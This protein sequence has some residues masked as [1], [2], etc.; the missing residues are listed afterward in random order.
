[1]RIL[2]KMFSRIEAYCEAYEITESQLGKKALNDSGFVKRLRDGKHSPRIST[3][4]KLCEYM[5]K[6][7]F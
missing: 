4:A 5:G 7:E 1:M 3:I 6:D 2:Q